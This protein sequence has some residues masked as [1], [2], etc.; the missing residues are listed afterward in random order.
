MNP[1]ENPR[2][3]YARRSAEFRMA[4]LRLDRQL[5]WAGNGRFGALILGIFFVFI[6]AAFRS[7][8][9]AWLLLPAVAFGATSAIFIRA[10]RRRNDVRRAAAY[11][12]LGL[13]RLEDRWQG[14]GVD[15][16][17]F[18]DPNHPYAAD[19]DLFGRA[20][21][22]ELLC[23]ARTRAG[24]AKLAGW[25][26]MPAP[27][28]EI[29]AR[30]EAARELASRSEWRE[31]LALAG[32]D[33]PAGLDTEAV[34]VWGAADS[35]PSALL[36]RWATILIAGMSLSL[37]AGWA[38]EG[39]PI[40]LPAAALLIQMGFAAALSRRVRLAIA[41]LAGRSRDLF[42]LAGLLACVESERFTSQRMRQL[43]AALVAGDEMPS[44]RLAELGR[45]VAR[46]DA[47]RN[48]FFGIVAPFLLWTTRT[49][50]AVSDWRR[51]T[52][53][54][55]ERWVTAIAEAEALAAIGTYGF[56]N[57]ADVYPEIGPAEPHFEAVALSHP[58]LPRDRAVP[59]DVTLTAQARLLI[60]SGSNMSGKSTLLRSIGIAAVLAQAGLPVRATRLRLSPLAIGATLR[61]Q[62]SLQTGKS[63]FY[64][65]II[66]LR[67]IVELAAGPRPVLYLLDEL[68]AGTNSHDRRV[69]ATAILRG[70]VQRLALGLVTTHDLALTHVAEEL[71]PHAV[72]IHFADEFINGTLHFDFRLR[73]GVVRHNNALALMRAVGLDVNP[74]FR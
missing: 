54:A 28:D 45:L 37:L 58:L 39:W 64:A 42:H 26:L 69:G 68:L 13:A 70:L 4:E 73:P 35:G 53:P 44:R 62:D 17:E 34:A 30:Q 61:I 16:D 1:L 40:L 20:S 52:G 36:W 43:Q 6:L 67:Q 29:V 56:E 65:E 71:A 5:A 8:S 10:D 50:L 11:H 57:P 38:A 12:D 59:N 24:R 2:A 33:L 3:E 72:N 51:A 14:L 60:V 66:R 41:G 7:L 18:G 49:A 19:L 15:G 55:L 31:R 23:T 63:R 48:Q 46:L 27:A 74:D 47:T 22:F 32:D 25:L 21:I 9:P